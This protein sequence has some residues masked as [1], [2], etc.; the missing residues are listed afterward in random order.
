MR[1]SALGSVLTKIFK[2]SQNYCVEK[3][4]QK[5][6]ENIQL[7]SWCLEMHQVALMT[8]VSHEMLA[9]TPT[10]TQITLSLLLTCVFEA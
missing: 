8:P 6:K 9:Q 5:L 2:K 10:G 7:L 3:P 1:L 4:F